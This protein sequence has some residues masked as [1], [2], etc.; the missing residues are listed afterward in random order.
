MEIRGKINYPQHIYL[1]GDVCD[2]NGNEHQGNP[3]KGITM[4]D[5][6]KDPDF[7]IQGQP[8]VDGISGYYIARKV[9]FH[10]HKAWHSYD[11]YPTDQNRAMFTF[12]SSLAKG[13]NGMT[14]LA[15]VM[16]PFMTLPN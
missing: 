1:I 2:A 12:A 15:H 8:N 7:D 9:K 5:V 3:I 16:P 13:K 6:Q 14:I 4:V 11:K 10:N